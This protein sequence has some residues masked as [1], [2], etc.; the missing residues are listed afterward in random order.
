M[1]QSSLVKIIGV[2]IILGVAGYIGW[3][4]SNT[5]KQSAGPK[6]IGISQYLPTLAGATQGFK[7]EMTTLGYVE[8]KD[9]TYVQEIFTDPALSSSTAHK[10]LDQK[11]DLIYAI[12]S[13]AARGAL[14]ATKEDGVATPIIF[15]HANDPVGEGFAQSFKSS[16][17]NATGVSV[18]IAEVTAKKLE[19]LKQINPKIKNLLTFDAKFSDPAQ[20]LTLKE[21][22]KQ[23]PNFGITVIKYMIQNPPGSLSNKEI[24]AYMGSL[25]PGA[26]DAFFQPAGPAASIPDTVKM[27]TV[28]NKR[29][30]I[31]SVFINL[32]FVELG[33]LFS[34]GHD[35]P[36]I[37]S[38]AAIMADKVLKGTKPSDIPI[39]FANKYSLDINLKTA[40]E[41]G[42]TIPDAMLTIANSKID[43]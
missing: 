6:K 22:A 20:V 15:T 3:S 40:A 31:P 27:L 37:G 28:E 29:L 19:F 36:A 17:N 38:Q 12:T 25:K 24:A 1:L 9:V 2:L 10:L 8:G 23:A 39:E 41:I 32:P 7:D 13:V 35:L 5:P 14:A 16:G 18:N 42:V 43:K 11:V 26:V 21:L 33:G 34:Y 4:Y 30:K